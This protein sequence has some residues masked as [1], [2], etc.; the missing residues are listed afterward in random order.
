MMRAARAAEAP[1]AAI[2]NALPPNSAVSPPALEALREP[3]QALQAR[4]KPLQLQ[5]DSPVMRAARAAETTLASAPNAM[6]SV[7]AAISSSPLSAAITRIIAEVAGQDERMSP[8]VVQRS[9]APA[10][11]AAMAAQPAL[12]EQP[13]EAATRAILRLWADRLVRAETESSF[14]HWRPAA[15]PLLAKTDQK[16]QRLP[17]FRLTAAPGPVVVIP[18][19]ASTPPAA[20]DLALTATRP[21]PIAS[22]VAGETLSLQEPVHGPQSPAPES[23]SIRFEG[24]ATA[25]LARDWAVATQSIAAK[26]P[27]GQE[28]EQ[29]L[30][31]AAKTLEQVVWMAAQRQGIS[32]ATLRLH[33]A[34][35]GQVEIQLAV[36]GKD[37]H[38]AI[39]VQGAGMRESVEA[40]LPRLRDQLEQQ[41]MTLAEANVSDSQ[42]RDSGARRRPVPM[43]M[44]DEPPGPDAAASGPV[45]AKIASNPDDGSRLVIDLYV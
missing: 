42:A 10:P 13:I 35:L 5:E 3:L 25:N 8:A 20:L 17:A 30:A 36:R 45:A 43:P 21:L 31:A 11:A 18:A 6:P 44:A 34:Q 7:Q 22:A 28:A 41:G 40:L 37:T 38:V 14:G 24:A 23:S 12:S 27:A 32:Q 1:L 39:S 19:A 9:L 29:R 15:E 4:L 16:D 33:P 2:L 26:T